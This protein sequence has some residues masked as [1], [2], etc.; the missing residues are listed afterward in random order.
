M[1]GTC[2]IRCVLIQVLLI[3]VYGKYT[4]ITVNCPNQTGTVG[5]PLRLTCSVTCEKCKPTNVC[6]WSNKKHPDIKCSDEQCNITTSDNIHTFHCTIP[7]ASEEHNGT[8]KFW[9]QMTTGTNET[10]FNV[11]IVPRVVDP[12]T[13]VALSIVGLPDAP[14]KLTANGRSP[15]VAVAVMVIFC[16]AICAMATLVFRGNKCNNMSI[17]ALCPGKIIT[18]TYPI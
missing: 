18:E 16:L 6:K 5:E 4:D 15:T 13:A 17:S 3:T 10:T 8:F 11:T 7:H 12:T 2:L 14:G 1:A 9:V